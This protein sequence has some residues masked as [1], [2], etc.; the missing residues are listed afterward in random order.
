MC[1]TLQPRSRS[2][3]TNV[4]KW[5]WKTNKC[6]LNLIGYKGYQEQSDREKFNLS[7][8]NS[9]HGLHSSNGK[10]FYEIDEIDEISVCVSDTEEEKT[11]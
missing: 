3:Q 5:G 2:G 4:I 10:G 1:A 9:Y 11:A 7:F 6:N 8:S